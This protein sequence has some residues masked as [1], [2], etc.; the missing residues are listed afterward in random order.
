MDVTACLF[1]NRRT[2]WLLFIAH[3]LWIMLLWNTHVQVLVCTDTFNSFGWIARPW[4]RAV[5]EGYNPLLSKAA[6]WSAKAALVGCARRASFYLTALRMLGI[7]PEFPE[8][9]FTCF[10]LLNSILI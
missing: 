1:A 9:A 6:R 7:K 5:G 2:L 4:W 8:S 3:R 10:S